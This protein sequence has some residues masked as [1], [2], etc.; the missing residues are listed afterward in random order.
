MAS[1]ESEETFRSLERELF[2]AYGK[3]PDLEA[4]DRLYADSFL[5]INADGSVTD[6][7]QV[8]E[9]LKSGLWPSDRIT[10]DEFRVRRY[11]DVAV[12]T[13]R[14]TYFKEG[15][16]VGAVRHTQVW[17]KLDGRWRLV[18]WQ[19]TSLPDEDHWGPGTVISPGG[20]A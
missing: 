5:A 17:A 10:S 14:S 19:G 18:G 2:N 7:G 15:Q 3:Q 16:K 20:E 9:F 11:G 6:K 4:I 1:T 13:G 8:I 12:I